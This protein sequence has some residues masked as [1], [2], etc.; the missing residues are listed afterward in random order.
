MNKNNK[1]ELVANQ[2]IDLINF[3]VRNCKPSFLQNVKQYIENINR[4]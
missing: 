3:K 1:K 4:K 2:I